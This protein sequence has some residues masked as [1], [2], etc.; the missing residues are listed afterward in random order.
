MRDYTDNEVLAMQEF[1]RL[2]Q[3]ICRDDRFSDIHFYRSNLNDIGVR[4]A[5]KFKGER[6]SVIPDGYG[7][8][9]EGLL[10]IGAS[11]VIGGSRSIDKCHFKPCREANDEVLGW[12]DTN[13]IIFGFDDGE[14]DETN[15]T[16]D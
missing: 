12:Q 14:D 7:S 11:D 13:S 15:K 2:A 3:E 10:E 4:L 16:S 1:D 6:F 5:F 8:K 9:E